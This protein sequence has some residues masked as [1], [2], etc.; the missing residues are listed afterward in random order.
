MPHTARKG[1]GEQRAALPQKPTA[2][3]DKCD[4]YPPPQRGPLSHAVFRTP[5]NFFI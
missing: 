2:S 5:V 3:R 4:Q 1:K